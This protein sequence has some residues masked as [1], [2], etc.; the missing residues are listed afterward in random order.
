MLK[1][2][3]PSRTRSSGRAPQLAPMRV[4]N[5]I[6]CDF[7]ACLDRR[8]GGEDDVRPDLGPGAIEALP[9]SHSLG[10]EL[11]TRE[12]RVPFIEVVDIWR[13]SERAQGAHAP[14]SQHD[15]LGYPLVLRASVEAPRDPAI[16]L[17]RRFEQV[18]RR[19]PIAIHLPDLT[20]HVAAFDRD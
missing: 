11:Q 5:S 8:V 18:E 20:R 15:L 3:P 6:G 19:I 16:L 10:D 12:H 2:L 17:L 9:R 7:V 4:I 1:G 14:D 13:N